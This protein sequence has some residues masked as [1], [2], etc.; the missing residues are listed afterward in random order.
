SILRIVGAHDGLGAKLIERNRFDGVWAS[1]L[2]IS[3]SHGVPDANILTM[4]EL[5]D[6]AS[7]MNHA[8]SLPV[9]CDCDTGFG[10]ALNAMHMVKKYEAAGMAAVVIE[11]KLFPKVNSFIPGRQELATVEEFMG[12]IGAAKNA[13]KNADFMVFARTEALIAGWG[14]E[15]ALRRAY[16]YAE[17]GADGIVI[18]SKAATPDEIFLFAERWSAKLPLVAIPT[19]YYEVT[20]QELAARGFKM[21]IYANQGIRASMRATDDVLRSIAATGSTAAVE[22][23]I[24]SMKEV[25]QIQGMTDMKRD[26]ERFA[27]KEPIHAVIPA[28]G[29]PPPAFREFL[30][31]K[32]L[33][34]LDL[35]GK[36]LLDRQTDLLRSCG[37]TD[38]CVVG[39]YHSDKIRSDGVSLLHNPDY[40]TTSHVYSF[41]L[42][43]EHFG[44][45]CVVVYSDVLFDRR[46]LENLLKSPYPLTIGIDRAYQTL[47]YRE[48]KLDLIAVEKSPNGGNGRS[49]Q[50]HQFKPVR[51]AG[52]SLGKD[53]AT[54]E[55]TGVAYFQEEGITLLGQAWERARAK[56][57]G[58][59]FYESPSVESADFMDFLQFLIDSGDPVH[60]M[61][62]EHGWSEIHSLDDYRRVN[63]HL[64][65]AVKIGR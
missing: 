63:A 3:A 57:K 59:A 35:G 58:R 47:P 64:K 55:F 15:E 23:K 50:L 60:G 17:A 39:G 54:H 31:G 25:F 9:I 62:V 19:T 27:V 65:E 2:E 10:N 32:P 38:I 12:K 44:K 14:M 40:K 49:L 18:H 33:C 5:L 16:A 46:A 6:A 56:F 43:Q 51:R 11:D 7:A 22:E 52:R 42:A 34:M 37:V 21:V 53:E 29:G 28:A 48:K 24:A 20:A 45:K 30:G 1:G 4:T 8:T 13:Q 36:T 61:E 26:E 41:M